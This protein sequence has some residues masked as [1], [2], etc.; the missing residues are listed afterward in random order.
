MKYE[1][2]VTIY[3][4]GLFL[5][6]FFKNNIRQ[7]KYAVPGQQI[8]SRKWQNYI[9]W[10]RWKSKK[11]S[12]I[13]HWKTGHICDTLL[14]TFFPF[15]LM[16]CQLKRDAPCHMDMKPE[17][18]KSNM[19]RLIVFVFYLDQFL[20][21]ESQRLHSTHSVFCQVLNMEVDLSWYE[22]PS[23]RSHLDQSMFCRILNVQQMWGHFTG[24][25]G[26]CWRYCPYVIYF[27]L[28]ILR[29]LLTCY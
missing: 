14:K 22:Q 3:L 16:Q 8:W 21:G 4:L 20:F 9:M 28:I 18:S 5:F 15:I 17:Q 26:P 12:K 1:L 10:L 19:D 6:S 23:R 29:T 7:P 2:T 11:N 24:P 13:T 27:K 25:V